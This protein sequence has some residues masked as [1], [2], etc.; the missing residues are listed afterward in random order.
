MSL[1]VGTFLR[2]ENEPPVGSSGSQTLPPADS[3]L[4]ASTIHMATLSPPHCALLNS[5]EMEVGWEALTLSSCKTHSAV[6]IL[7]SCQ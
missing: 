2:V 5:E 3:A 4:S 1:G 7:D 6:E